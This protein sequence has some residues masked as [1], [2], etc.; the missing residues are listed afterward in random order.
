MIDA[1]KFLNCLA[2]KVFCAGQFI[3]HHESIEF[4]PEPDVVHEYVGHVP[5][6][7]E[8]AIAVSSFLLRKFLKRL[9]SFHLEQV[10]RTSKNWALHT[11]A[12]SNWD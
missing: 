8:P 11:F 10:M 5:M 7:A 3:R 12:H 9:E 1:R 2:F 4:T 6:F